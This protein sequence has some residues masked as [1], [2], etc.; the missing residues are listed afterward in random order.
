V[1]EASPA[2]DSIAAAAQ[3]AAAPEFGEP[4]AE[5]RRTV[6]LLMA[7]L[8]YVGYATAIPA[9]ASPWIAK[10]F[11]LSESQVAVVF[12]WLAVASLGA[13]ALARMVDRLGRRRVLMWSTV[14]MPVCA[15]GAALSA[16]LALFVAFEI[17]LSAFAGAAAASS[18]VMI[19]ET[20][21]I[22]RRARGQSLGGLA[23]VAGAGVCVILM[24]ALVRFGWSWRWLL[25]IAAIGLAML[26]QL[27]RALPE[28]ARWRHESEAGA[29]AP[30]RFYDVFVPLYR[31]RSI[32]LVV[33]SILA[34]LS[35]EGVTSYTYFHAVSVVKLSAD[36][37]SAITLFGGGLGMLG[38]PVGAWSSERFGR[39]PTVVAFGVATSALALGYYWG[40]PAHFTHPALW[41]AAAF[42]LTTVSTNAT[43]VASNA[44][45]TELFP[46][47]LRGT[48]IGW[49]ALTGAG[50]SLAAETTIALLARRMGGLSIVTGWLSL[51]GIP[52][53]ILFGV[54]IHETR[55]LSLDESASEA[56][57]R[58]SRAQS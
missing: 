38:F 6:R 24:P 27:G 3:A 57:F 7:M 58:A 13:L 50:G 14:A 15:L 47:A 17:V 18:I 5:E 35:A 40:P 46:T 54:M 53:A 16:S 45:T 22:Q 19:A 42:L 31:R 26:P 37:A 1:N 4:T 12:A 44:A 11:T 56:E 30:T 33:C 34:A 41:L 39:V 48:M 8:A 2:P 21:P 20:L 36:A 23:T 28:S 55:G 43:T 52:A 9:I 49:F 25:A 32:T 10:S 29:A 51:L